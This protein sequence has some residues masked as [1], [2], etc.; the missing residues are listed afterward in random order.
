VPIV[1]E[2]GANERRRQIL[3]PGEKAL[4]DFDRDL[5]NALFSR[6]VPDRYAVSLDQAWHVEG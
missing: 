5:F 2:M 3:S 4:Q 6:E 1:V